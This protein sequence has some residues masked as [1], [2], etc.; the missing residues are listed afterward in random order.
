MATINFPTDAF[1]VAALDYTREGNSGVDA[2]IWRELLQ[3]ARDAGA[4]NVSAT[5]YTEGTVT[6]LTFQDNGRGMDR[7]TLE[8]G[9]L[10]YG[11]SIKQVGNAGGFG[12]AKCLLV[13][14]PT[15]CL[16]ETKDLAV[17]VQGIEYEWL[18]AKP[19]NGTR[20]TLTI[21]NAGFE[22]GKQLTPTFAGLRFLME[23]SNMGDM[24][25]CCNGQFV[26][27]THLREGEVV[28]E[29]KDYDAKAYKLDCDP[30]KNNYGGNV[31]VVQHRGIWVMDL[32]ISEEVKGAVWINIETEPRKVLNAARVSL[33]SYDLREG[34]DKFIGELSRSPKQTLKTKKYAK[35]WDGNGL[36]RI[37]S[38]ARAV[39]LVTESIMSESR[40]GEPVKLVTD[41][42]TAFLKGLAEAMK[43][44]G[45]MRINAEMLDP[46]R[47]D[48]TTNND[49]L[50][51]QVACLV[52]SP[53]LMIVNEREKPVH[54]QWMPE[55]MGVKCK[56]LLTVWSEMVKQFLLLSKAYGVTFGVGFIFSDDTLALWRK[57]EDGSVWFLL[58]PLGTDDNIRFN[59]SDNHD[60]S[61]MMAEA[62]HEV[63][64]Q[65]SRYSHHGDEFANRLTDLMALA[66]DRLSIFNGIW[67][68]RTK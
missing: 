61:V 64:H 53:A 41:N 47:L 1:R 21:D 3:N 68:I 56:N 13:F 29:W 14:A 27:D 31:L 18:E 63:C 45:E 5:V 7:E 38:A 12:M 26:A 62:A 6:T 16:I 44:S 59:L 4:S 54:A 32:Q 43:P 24:T 58:N 49:D 33:A 9:L 11:G 66:L 2:C 8:K 15:S 22:Q 23:R 20:F 40:T 39:Q 50:A 30:V 52:W 48:L 19:I 42:Q 36:T 10:S 60:R 37:E 65:I 34:F 57:E 67:K 46:A 28:R 55:T 25:V 51:E 35:R 17:K